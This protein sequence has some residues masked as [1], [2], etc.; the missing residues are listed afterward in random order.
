MSY[1]FGRRLRR[2]QEKNMIE[3]F[4]KEANLSGKQLDRALTYYSESRVI[5][6][7]DRFNKMINLALGKYKHRDK[8]LATNEDIGDA[9]GTH[10]EP[11]TQVTP[12]QEV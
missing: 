10:A 7:K 5:G 4:K 9:F 3:E 8:N 2:Q 6:L 12:T 11:E 1:N